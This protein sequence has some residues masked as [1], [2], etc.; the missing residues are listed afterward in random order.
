MVLTFFDGSCLPTPNGHCS[1]SYLF[2]RNLQAKDN[3]EPYKKRKLILQHR[4]SKSFTGIPVICQRFQDKMVCLYLHL[5]NA[6]LLEYLCLYG[7]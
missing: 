5:N 4:Y 1:Q 7:D 2:P 6:G 3:P